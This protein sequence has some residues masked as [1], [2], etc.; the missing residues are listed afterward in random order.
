[1]AQRL[2]PPK[3]TPGGFPLDESQAGE[4]EESAM[5]RTKKVTP[6]RHESS[7]GGSQPQKAQARAQ[8]TDDEL[9]RRMQSALEDVYEVL[10]VA[11]GSETETGW[12]GLELVNDLTH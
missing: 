12:A 7:T 3:Q 10:L 8:T 5:T 9:K 6:R 4:G 11:D 1:M 2:F